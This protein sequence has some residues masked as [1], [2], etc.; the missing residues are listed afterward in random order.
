MIKIVRCLE[1]RRIKPNTIIYRTVEEV[2]EIF[3][4]DKGSV[5]IGF[6][7]SRETKYVIRL[8]KGGVVGIYNV[9]YDKKT[10]F[11]YKVKHFFEGFSIRRANWMSII[12]SEEHKDIT[13]FM[14]EQIKQEYEVSIKFKVLEVYNKEM[15][16]LKKRHDKDEVMT[17]MGTKSEKSIMTHGH[18]QKESISD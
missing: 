2:D 12:F 14:R 8:E 15:S 6:E 18:D 4:I 9:T 11:L 7:I 17:V 13:I 1:P 16:K 3:F 10:I 5:D